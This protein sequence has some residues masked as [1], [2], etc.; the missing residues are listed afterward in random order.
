[1]HHF[2]VMHTHA[3]QNTLHI[4]TPPQCVQ[5]KP[6]SNAKQLKSNSTYNEQMILGGELLQSLNK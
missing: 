5:V 3:Y 1:M 6:L 2:I 4:K